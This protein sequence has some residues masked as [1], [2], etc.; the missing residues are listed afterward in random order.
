M[1]L[2]KLG[3]DCNV[4]ILS[5]VKGFDQSNLFKN[6]FSTS[7]TGDVTGAELQ[8]YLNSMNDYLGTGTSF[9]DWLSN[10]TSEDYADIDWG[11]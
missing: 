1:N 8:D 3:K 10:L 2:L 7:S 6:I 11:V 9:D 5:G 4:F